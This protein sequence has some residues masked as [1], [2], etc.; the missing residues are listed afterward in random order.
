MNKMEASEK[1][2]FILEKYHIDENRKQKL[3]SIIK[4]P[5]RSGLPIRG[6]LEDLKNN[7][8]QDFSNEDKLLIDDLLC[9]YG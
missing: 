7:K 4:D 6:C 2:I 5:R 3:I 8:K 1:L 9:Y